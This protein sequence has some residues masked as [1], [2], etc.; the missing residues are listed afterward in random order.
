M[1]FGH[2]TRTGTLRECTVH[3]FYPSASLGVR[4]SEA[5]ALPVRLC[6][7]D[8]RHASPLN[9]GNPRTGLAHQCRL[10]R[11]YIA[12]GIYIIDFV[13]LPLSSRR[14]EI[15]RPSHSLS[16]AT[17]L[18]RW[19]MFSSSPGLYPATKRGTVMVGDLRRF[20]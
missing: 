17:Q 13:F 19:E 5:E 11:A 20:S 9:G 14:L 8:G 1:S 12:T 4:L 18:N 3:L 2:A 6:Q 7:V 15:L 16:I 10:T